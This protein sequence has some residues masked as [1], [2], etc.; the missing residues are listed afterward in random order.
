MICTGYY[1][2]G[3]KWMKKLVR[4]SLYWVFF[5]FAALIFALTVGEGFLMGGTTDYLLFGILSSLL[6]LALKE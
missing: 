4:K 6:A 1:C 3:E 5:A 2:E